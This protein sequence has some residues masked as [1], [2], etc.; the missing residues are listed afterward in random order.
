MDKQLIQQAIGK[1]RESGVCVEQ[2]IVPPKVSQAIVPKHQAQ[3][4]RLIQSLPEST[5]SSLPKITQLQVRSLMLK[6]TNFE[7][8]DQFADYVLLFV[9]PKIESDIEMQMLKMILHDFAQECDLTFAEMKEAL[10]LA[11]RGELKIFSND[12]E[13]TIRLYREVNR[14]KLE[15]IAVGYIAYRNDD[16]QYRKGVKELNLI[17]NPPKEMTPQEKQAKN[18]QAFLDF[19]EDYKQ[20]QKLPRFIVWFY[21][22]LHR[23]NLIKP[24]VLALSEEEKKQ[25]R[26][27]VAQK[28]ADELKTTN[29][30]R[31]KTY[32]Q[33]LA[34]FKNGQNEDQ[35]PIF[36]IK[37]EVAVKWYMEKNYRE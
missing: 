9:N 31:Y 22:A 20:T 33:A 30:E 27:E 5:L 19:I 32:K 15:E 14:P 26:K 6:H 7:E 13:E 12:K 16:F 10:K 3:R 23:K 21:D 29:K 28:L 25:M 37:K 34:D 36:G 24:F 1:V 35:E 4:Y 2:A 17:L 8:R 11:S 18:E